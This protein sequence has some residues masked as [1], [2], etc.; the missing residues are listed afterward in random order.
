MKPTAP[1]SPKPAKPADANDPHANLDGLFNLI[2]ARVQLTGHEWE[3]VNK[4]VELIRDA[5]PP[6]KL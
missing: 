1:K 4:G 3:A 6:R 2:K 5:L